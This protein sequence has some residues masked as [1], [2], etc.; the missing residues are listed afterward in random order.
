MADEPLEVLVVHKMPDGTVA[1]GDA[2]K[3]F[4]SCRTALRVPLRRKNSLRIF[5]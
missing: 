3:N 2:P 5:I 1:A 4:A